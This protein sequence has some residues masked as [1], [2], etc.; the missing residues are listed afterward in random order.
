M[1]LIAIADAFAARAHAAVVNKDGSIGHLRKYSKEPYITHPREVAALVASHG[2]SD[3]EVAAALAHDVLEDTPITAEQMIAALGERVTRIVWEVTDV[4]KWVGN[5]ERREVFDHARR[6]AASV[7]GQNITCADMIS[8]TKSIAAHDPR[9]ARYYLPKKEGLL[10]WMT[11]ANPEIYD[12]AWKTLRDGQRLL[13][14]HA[15]DPG[16]G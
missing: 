5:S 16:N 15:L 6:A 14:Q 2:A 13:V 1:N 3:E 4:P 12:L 11:R 7:S 8:N 9:F 10:R